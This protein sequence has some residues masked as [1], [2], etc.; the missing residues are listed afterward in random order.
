MQPANNPAYG[1]AIKQARLDLQGVG[2]AVT[3]LFATQ[4]DRLLLWIPVFFA[5]GIG[6]YFS[7]RFEPPVVAA[8]PFVLMGLTAL[9]LFKDRREESVPYAVGWLICLFVFTVS[10]GFLAAQLRTQQLQAPVLEREIGPVGLT[11]IIRNIERLE[12]GKGNR[13]IL[14]HVDI[15]NLAASKTPAQIRIKLHDG[16]NVAIGD[17]I[18]VLA[19][20]NP[21]SAPVMPG[22]FDFQRYAYFKQIGAFGFAY[23]EPE[24][25][26]Q[27]PDRSFNIFISGLRQDII[28][29]IEK[30]LPYPEASFAVTMLTGQR[31]T[32]TEEDWEAMRSSGLA[33]M[34]AISGLHVGLI[35][36][37]I[38]FLSRL[39][40]ALSPRLALYHPIKKYA[41]LIAFTG[42]LGYTLLVGASIPT[43]R[44]LIMTGIA[45][46]AIILDRDAIS[47]RLAAIAA[48]AVLLISPEAL[49][50]AGFQMSFAAVIGLIAFY[51]AVRP[52]WSRWHSRA[53]WGRRIGLYMLGIS[54]TTVI[55][56]LATA[57][58]S[59]YHFQ[60]FAPYSLPANLVAVP[61]M[62]FVVMP[63]VVL[64][65]LLLPFGLE[66][67]GLAIMGKGISLILH[68]AHDVAAAPGAALLV[69]AWPFTAFMIII[70][71]ALFFVLWQGHLRFITVAGILI[72]VFIIINHKQDDIIITSSSDLVTLQNGNGLYISSTRHDRFSSEVIARHYG[73]K[74]QYVKRFPLEGYLKDEDAIKCGELGCRLKHKGKKIALSYEQ[75]ALESD[76]KWSDILISKHPV[77][78]WNC[79]ANIIIDTF[80]LWREG[81]HSLR[82]VPATGEIFLNSVAKYRGQRPWTVNNR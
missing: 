24:I 28:T 68:I 13:V 4:K 73:Y 52:Y 38:F 77:K 64:T 61:V 80:D 11:G 36:G 22:S 21:P 59:I 75:Q 47:L 50:S 8:L 3:A 12:G 55:A 65:L 63:S 60:H 72:S 27:A 17:K 62:G 16:S 5:V 70:C 29:R 9:L 56:T 41:A 39:L 31:S 32:I 79:S 26:T 14:G 78:D 66:S 82:I 81:G 45:L 10:S 6:L 58:F 40:M 54:M 44:A 1:A 57:P 76:C 33:H 37:V 67:V 15:E 48:F 71:S 74:E 30:I 25:L 20:L 34:L 49:F 43:Q 35:A 18:K 51:E 23:R 53:G 19:G 42:A 46:F 69:P 7:L 2:K